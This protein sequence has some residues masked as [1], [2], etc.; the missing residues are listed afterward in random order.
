MKFK[1]LI[2]FINY[3][4]AIDDEEVSQKSFSIKL[5]SDERI[6]ELNELYES[7][8]FSELSN[9][10]SWIMH[11][12]CNEEDRSIIKYEVISRIKI[13]LNLDY[14]E[15]EQKN[16]LKSM[17][18]KVECGSNLHYFS[19]K[20]LYIL[21]I[22]YYEHNSVTDEQIINNK[23]KFENILKYRNDL[24]TLQL[25]VHDMSEIDV[26]G[27]I[28]AMSQSLRKLILLKPSNLKILKILQKCKK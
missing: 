28:K 20:D 15:D 23:K 17:I 4:I 6:S 1:L 3:N 26:Y 24:D 21:S 14:I 27:L 16:L 18:Y 25:H 19:E 11:Y 5:F 2:I 7:S 10:V 9:A 22:Y 8:D 13:C 12:I